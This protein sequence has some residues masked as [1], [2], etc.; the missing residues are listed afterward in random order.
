[1]AYATYG[2]DATS[3][4]SS[5][6]V[7]PKV[8][9]PPTPLLPLAALV[10]S[11]VQFLAFSGLLFVSARLFGGRG[12]FRRQSYL[13][14]LFWTPLMIGA[15]IAAFLPS[16]GIML[17]ALLRSYALILCAPALAAANHLSL[18]RAVAA[19][20]L[21]IACGVLLGIVVLVLVGPT[22]APRL[23]P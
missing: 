2:P 1:V 22:I 16:I 10:G 17:G 18:R 23:I 11:P 4:Y 20:L 7:G 15:A 8:Q 5:L 21:P 9:L 13:L 14:V 12:V 6:P 3:G 19:L